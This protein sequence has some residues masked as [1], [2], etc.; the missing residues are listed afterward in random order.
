MHILYFMHNW[1]GNFKALFELT[2]ASLRFPRL[3]LT[4][5]DVGVYMSEGNIETAYREHG[6]SG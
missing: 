3:T 2:L 4:C 5:E 6:S 1:W